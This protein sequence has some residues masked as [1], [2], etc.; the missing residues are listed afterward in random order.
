MLG[1]HCH[2]IH[3]T[4]KYTE[5]L[6][7]IHLNIV[8][9]KRIVLIL[10]ISRST[11]ISA[12]TDATVRKSHGKKIKIQISIK[13]NYIILPGVPTTQVN[14]HL[15]GMRFSITNRNS[16]EMPFFCYWIKEHMTDYYQIWKTQLALVKHIICFYKRLMLRE[17]WTNTCSDLEKYYLEPDKLKSIL[18]AMNWER[19][20]S[21]KTINRK[22]VL[23]ENHLQQV[24]TLERWVVAVKKSRVWS[25]LPLNKETF[26]LWILSTNHEVVYFFPRLGHLNKKK[27]QTTSLEWFA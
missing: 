6:Y 9:Y 19:L 1:G 24:R 15:F 14:L 7:C 11:K 26:T 23:T 18:S 8:I 12:Y 25:S 10:G 20:S 22:W 13:M 2:F 5:R 17:W 16:F 4:K 3:I 21:L 27:H